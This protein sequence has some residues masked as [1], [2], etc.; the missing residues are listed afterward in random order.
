M[1]VGKGI[2]RREGGEVCRRPLGPQSPDKKG[3]SSDPP[4]F[5]STT[6]QLVK[7]DLAKVGVER[8]NRFTRSNFPKGNQAFNPATFGWPFSFRLHAA[9]MSPRERL[10]RRPERTGRSSDLSALHLQ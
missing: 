7:P 10:T 9:T 1:A 4:F 6:R 5:F 3:G 8:S 2:G